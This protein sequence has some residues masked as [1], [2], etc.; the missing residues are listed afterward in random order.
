[1]SLLLLAEGSL[2]LANAS[3]RRVIEEAQIGFGRARVLPA[4]IEIML[5]AG[6]LNAARIAAD[7]LSSIATSV[8][9]AFVRALSAYSTG[10]TLLAEGNAPAALETLRVALRG[11]HEIDAPYEAA[12]VRVLIAR[13]C[14][15][16]G[17]T[18]GASR[19]LVAARAVF[20]QLGAATEIASVDRLSPARPA[21]PG[22]LTPREAQVLALLA[23]GK[24]NREI[25]SELVL[26]EHTVARHV[27][28][29]LGK[30][31]VSSRTAASAFAFEHHLI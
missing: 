22:G 6:D 2:D 20:E 3:I 12:R 4:Y 21:H 19:D 10:A 25:S 7:E 26:S 8:D 24:T 28:N 14:L 9:T 1:M 31:G 5:A 29:I 23:K 13:A 30:L 16:L 17:D 11:W 18:D 15:A 27:Q